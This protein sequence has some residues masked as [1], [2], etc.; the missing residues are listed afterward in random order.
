[1]DFARF[2]VASISTGH[3]AELLASIAAVV[4]GGTSLLGGVGFIWGSAVGVFIPAVLAN[5]LVIA[6]IERFWQDVIV[7]FIL[8]AAVWFD[9]WRRSKR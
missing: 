3:S 5:G 2:N 8:I 6:G 1:M 7:G 9:Q 4:I